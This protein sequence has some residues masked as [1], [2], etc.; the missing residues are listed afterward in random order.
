[1]QNEN[2]SFFEEA[3]PSEIIEKCLLVFFPK[4]SSRFRISTE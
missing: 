4:D 3:Q 1:M 2:S